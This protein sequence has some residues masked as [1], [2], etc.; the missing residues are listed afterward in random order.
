MKSTSPSVFSLPKVKAMEPWHISGGT[1]TAVSTW[2]ALSPVSS[3][4]STF[5]AQALPLAEAMP[6][7]LSHR[8]QRF[9]LYE[10]YPEADVAGEPLDRVAGEMQVIDLTFSIPFHSL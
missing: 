3:A 6:F 9:A 2:D 4:A 8:R 1:P 7:R 10:L 5:E